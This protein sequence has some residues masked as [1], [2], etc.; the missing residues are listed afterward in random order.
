MCE[1]AEIA[2]LR[3]RFG[4]DRLFR[5]ESALQSYTFQV[6][7]DVNTQLHEQCDEWEM[8]NLVD[9]SNGTA[10]MTSVFQCERKVLLSHAMRHIE[11]VHRFW[12]KKTGEHKLIERLLLTTNGM[13]EKEYAETISQV[14][15]VER[16]KT[17]KHNKTS[18]GELSEYHSEI[19]TTRII[20]VIYGF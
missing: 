7:G 16:V 12:T 4:A 13:S 9:E 18:F 8:A 20:R 1:S 10:A 17:L 15:E 19:L 3:L 6:V 14:L 11:M 2:S 5:L